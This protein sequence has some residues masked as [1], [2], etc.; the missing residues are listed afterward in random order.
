MVFIKCLTVLALIEVCQV[1]F[2]E[3]VV[4]WKVRNGGKEEEEERRK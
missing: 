2:A 1:G 3:G 4:E